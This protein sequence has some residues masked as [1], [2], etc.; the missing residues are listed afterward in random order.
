[1]HRQGQ[2]GSNTNGRWNKLPK[3]GQGK[4]PKRS[5]YSTGGSNAPRCHKQCRDTH[6]QCGS[7]KYKTEILEDIQND[8]DGSTVRVGNKKHHCQK[9][10][11]LPYKIST[12]ALWH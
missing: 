2:L 12:M 4:R 3:M 5:I 10:V 1:M 7:T 6:T 9:W 11:E 8:I